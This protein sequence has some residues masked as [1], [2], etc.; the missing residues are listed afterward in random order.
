MYAYDNKDFNETLIFGGSSDVVMEQRDTQSPRSVIILNFGL[1]LIK[2]ITMERL[3]R[4]FD[5][6]LDPITIIKEELGRNSPLF[7]WKTTTPGLPI[8]TN[9]KIFMTT[10]LSLLYQYQ[11]RISSYENK[12]TLSLFSHKN[13]FDRK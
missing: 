5:K 7:I 4:A 9:V 2:A 6:F 11:R 13:I 8:H 3:K 10:Q 1:H 12:K